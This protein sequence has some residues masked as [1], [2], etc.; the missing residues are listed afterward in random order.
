MVYQLRSLPDQHDLLLFAP[1]SRIDFQKV[2]SARNQCT[3][4][5]TSVPKLA[6]QPGRHLLQGVCSDTSPSQI[7]DFE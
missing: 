5:V 4:F 6:V 1:F 7:V 3:T 2:R